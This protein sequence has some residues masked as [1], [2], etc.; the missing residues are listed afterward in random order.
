ME[1]EGIAYYFKHTKDKHVLV[2]TDLVS[3]HKEFPNYGTIPYTGSSSGKHPVEGISLWGPATEA[4]TGTYVHTDFDFT[5]SRAKL[6]TKEA[7][8]RGYTLSKFE[9]FEYPGGYDND[10][11]GGELAKIRMEEIQSR[12][13]TATGRSTAPGI[14]VGSVFKFE[15]HPRK[16]QNKKYLVTWANLTFDG[17]NFVA[18]KADRDTGEDFFKCSFGVL[19]IEEQFRPARATASPR[20]IGPQTAIITGP[21]GEEIHTD[22]HGR[23]TVKFPWD[24]YN[25]EDENS[26]CWIRVSQ[27]WAGK[28]WGSMHIPRIGQEVI[29]EYLDGDP[30]RPIITGRVYNDATTPP[31]DLPAKKNISGLRS[32]STKGGAPTT[33]FN[34]VLMDDTKGSELLSIQAEK[35]RRVLVKNDNSE[36]VGHDEDITIDKDRHKHVKKNETTDV[37]ENRTETVGK[38]ETIT[39]KGN[40][41]EL[42]EKNED[43]LIHDNRNERVD[44]DETVSIGK[45]R[46]H[47]VGEV[48]KLQVGK[49]LLVD[50]GDEIVFRTGKAMIT[51]KKDG[52][53]TINGVDI[54]TIAK[55]AVST[56]ADKDITMKGKNVKQN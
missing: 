16:D 42:V 15:K 17:G 29:V 39:I 11:V 3:Q 6:E 20:I 5:K 34:E 7:K 37:D 13:V 44:K 21:K 45:N 48:D 12:H 56:K 41:T 55:G 32:N 47:D 43:I 18:G 1:R 19:S 26:S 33:N 31:Y 40:R 36:H 35:D 46:T 4:Q 50:V 28:G 2:L 10:G 51:M 22:K 54:S 38:N 9:R 30:D 27:N 8:T 14:A 23:V 25:P 24:R 53:I 49:Q 52:T